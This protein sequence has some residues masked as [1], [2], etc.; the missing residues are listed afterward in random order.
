M[1]LRRLILLL[2]LGPLHLLQFRQRLLQAPLALA[3]RPLTGRL[4]LRRE[5][6]VRGGLLERLQMLAGRP[7]VL[8]QGLSFLEAVGP[9]VG[10]D[11]GAVL[12]DPPDR[13][14]PGLDQGRQH[15]GQEIVQGLLV[16]DPKVVEGMIVDRDPAAEPTV[17]VALGA[18]PVQLSTA[19]DALG[20]GV[21]PQRQQQPRIRGGASGPPAARPDGLKKEG[22]VPALDQSPDG[23]HEVVIGHQV[24]PGPWLS[25]HPMAIGTPQAWGGVLIRS[26]LR[27]LGHVRVPSVVA[28]Y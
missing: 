6:R 25:D 22:Q 19:A 5:L 4:L 16:V 1:V 20:R 17:R 7:Q 11:T 26:R 8:L 3:G 12:G 13:N 10:A 24:I 27:W 23:P 18:E 14:D 28:R 9:G 15:L 21:Q 2:G